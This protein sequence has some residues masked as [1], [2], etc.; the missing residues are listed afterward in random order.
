MMTVV[1]ARDRDTKPRKYAA[2]GIPYFWLVEMAEG[3]QRP[4]VRVYAIDVD[5]SLDALKEP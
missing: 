2:A 4:V 5:V 1:P 3:N